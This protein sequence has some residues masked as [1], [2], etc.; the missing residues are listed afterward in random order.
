MKV[1]LVKPKFGVNAS[2]EYNPDKKELNVCAG[3]IG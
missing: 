1:F 3:S 2:G